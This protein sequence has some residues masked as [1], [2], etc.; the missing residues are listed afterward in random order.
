MSKVLNTR[1]LFIMNAPSPYWV[2]YAKALSERYECCF[3]YYSSCSAIGRPSWW[4]QE[5][6]DNQLIISEG[7]VRKR[8][9]FFDFKICKRISDFKPDIVFASGVNIASNLLAYFFSKARRIKFI[10]HTEI[11]RRKSGE[12]RSI[13]SKLIGKIYSRADLIMISSEEGR[14]FW[15]KY[16]KNRNLALLEVS[17]MVDNYLCH[18]VRDNSKPLRVFFGHRL[19]EEYSPIAALRIFRKL[20]H[21]SPSVKLYMNSHGPLRYRVDEYIL[22]YK[23]KGVVFIEVNCELDLDIYYRCGDVSISPAKY[24]H[25]NI[26]TNEA[27]SS[28]MAIL[29]SD[30]VSYHDKQ[31][32]F[33]DNGYI[34][35]LNDSAFVDKLVEYIEVPGL[36]KRHSLNSKKIADELSTSAILNRFDEHIASII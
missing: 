24:S 34:L 23:L 31:I 3:I 30:K 12:P 32:E 15:S 21:H 6:P 36:L 19:T 28:G 35:P 2:N 22:E 7:V 20:Q 13:L 14:F 8:N 1:I 33:F 4:D 27:M 17:G 11:W 26:G 29:I 25:G 16:F 5:L 10:Y 9:W 18:P